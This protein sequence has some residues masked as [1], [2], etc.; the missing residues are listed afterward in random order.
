MKDG[1][2]DREQKKEL[3]SRLMRDGESDGGSEAEMWGRGA[4]VGMIYSSRVKAYLGL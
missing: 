3:E 1:E 4:F 2:S